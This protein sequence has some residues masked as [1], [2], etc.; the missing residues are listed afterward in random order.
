MAQSSPRRPSALARLQQDVEKSPSPKRSE[1]T[2]MDADEGARMARRQS[3][4]QVTAAQDAE[5]AE[6]LAEAA[7]R[8]KHELMERKEIV[9][10]VDGLLEEERERRVSLVEATRAR[11]EAA[12]TYN[13]RLADRAMDKERE[14]R[15]S[16]GPESAG[17]KSARASLLV[18]L[19]GRVGP[20]PN[21][22][23]GTSMM[24]SLQDLQRIQ[25][26]C[27][28]D[29]VAIDLERMQCWSEA[30]AVVYFE[31]GG[32]TCPPSALLGR[33][34]SRPDIKLTGEAEPRVVAA[35]AAE[36]PEQQL[37]RRQ[38]IKKVT[39]AQ[40]AE[41]ARQLAEAAA[42]EKAAA[43]SVCLPTPLS[44]PPPAN[45]PS[46]MCRAAVVCERCGRW[47]GTRSSRAST[48]LLRRSAKG[49]CRWWRRRE[50]ARRRRARIISASPTVRWTR[51]A[52]GASQRGG[53]AAPSPRAH[54]A[55]SKTCWRTS[56]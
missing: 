4:K 14:R 27:W 55:S 18:D 12:R 26:A 13:Q 30:E 50:R 41:Q 33:R 32:E 46:A 25:Q 51:S 9:A 34:K 21:S 48:R 42:R 6:Q 7:A 24:L 49:A 10:R 44:P 35:D 43:V 36:E 5:R 20:P 37:V 28:A 3:I 2:V 19:K 29:D 45:V 8:E 40:D 38:S 16:E 22:L 1:D 52:S 39:A 54:T 53:H 47:S 15:L 56:R 17:Q 31:S 23:T 11:E